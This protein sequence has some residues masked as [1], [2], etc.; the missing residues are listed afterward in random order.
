MK[1]KT[2]IFLLSFLAFFQLQVGA[3]KPY[4]EILCETW[5]ISPLLYNNFID[6]STE[7]KHW[8]DYWR[9]GSKFTSTYIPDTLCI[10]I[11]LDL[12]M[13]HMD[14]LESISDSLFYVV[15]EFHYIYGD[16]PDSYRLLN[17]KRSDTLS[18][19]NKQINLNESYATMMDNYSLG[20]S[21]ATVM[22]PLKQLLI[23]D[24]IYVHGKP[25]ES[26]DGKGR[27]LNQIVIDSYLIDKE[28]NTI[29]FWSFV[30]PVNG[31]YADEN[32]CQY[33]Y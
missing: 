32:C 15:S 13:Y 8:E 14:N 31:G 30:F 27:F 26:Y 2:I 3:Q 29:C 9:D 20:L 17:P 28:K 11:L 5:H 21:L 16:S 25:F 6:V 10:D 1:Y 12:S 4:N 18:L 23:E 24:N 22:L 7:V 33:G 19:L